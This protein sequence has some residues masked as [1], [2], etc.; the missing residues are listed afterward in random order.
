MNTLLMVLKAMLEIIA[1]QQ[2]QINSITGEM[3]IDNSSQLTDG[4]F[5]DL[6]AQL[7]A[8][9]GTPDALG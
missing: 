4:D 5:A 6:Q 2:A 7:A 9:A 8:L 3:E 1:N